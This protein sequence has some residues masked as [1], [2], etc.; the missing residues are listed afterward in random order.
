MRGVNQEDINTCLH[1]SLSPCLIAG[2]SADG[3]AYAEA[4]QGILA[5]IGLSLGLLEV[6]YGNH[7]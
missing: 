2:A 5:G 4:S 7:S 6:L 1:K 3:G